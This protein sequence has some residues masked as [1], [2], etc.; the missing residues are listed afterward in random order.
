[1]YPYKTNTSEP[2]ITYSNI[3]GGWEGEG[4]IDTDPLFNDD[5]TLSE[6]SPCIDAGTADINGD[7]Q[8]D[9]TDYLGSAPDMGAFEY[10]P[11]GLSGDLTGDGYVNVQD[12]V[13]LVNIVLGFSDPIAGSDISGDGTINVIDIVMLIDYILYN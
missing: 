2:I 4:N 8:S 10:I 7:G 12:I 3:E 11:E 5:F 9:I 1:M 13:L 6:N